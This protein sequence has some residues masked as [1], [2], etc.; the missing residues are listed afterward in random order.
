MSKVVNLQG[1]IIEDNIIET[2]G[3]IVES[4]EKTDN[5]IVNNDV[6]P[7]YE[8]NADSLAELIKKDIEDHTYEYSSRR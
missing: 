1:E 7:T 4:N 5:Y 8:L 3:I 6:F 2:S